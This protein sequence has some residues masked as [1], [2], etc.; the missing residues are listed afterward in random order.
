MA[1]TVE[2]VG[3]YSPHDT[4]KRAGFRKGDVLIAFD[5]KSTLRRESDLIAYA[6][7]HCRAGA[8][9]PV[10]VLRDGKRITLTLPLQ[11]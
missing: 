1:L 10:T 2:H 4:A 5:G 8:Q 11:I 6:L 9:I 3:E 7:L